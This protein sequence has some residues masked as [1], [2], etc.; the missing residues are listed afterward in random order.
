MGPI[1]RPGRAKGDSKAR[2]ITAIPQVAQQ[3]V[4]EEVSESYRRD[5]SLTNFHHF[6]SFLP[7][8][9]EASSDECFPDGVIAHP[10]DPFH[11]DWPF[12]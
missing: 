4:Q 3:G 8:T 6:S 10:D 7:V 12:W 9:T 5:S 2:E 11:S 1:R